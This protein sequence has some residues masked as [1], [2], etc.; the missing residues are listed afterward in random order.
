[1]Q[2]RLSGEG[3]VGRDGGPPGNLYVYLEV[4]EHEFFTRDGND[5]IYL[6]PINL[7]E[8]AL[9]VEK[10]IPTLNDAQETLKVPQGTQPG[11]EFRIRGKGI[12][13][14]QSSRRGDLRVLV[15][16]QVPRSL[17]AHQKELLEELSRSFNFNGDT[18]DVSD[19]GQDSGDK[20]NGGL[21]NKIKDTFV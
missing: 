13:H 12:P 21:F 20:R 10:Q 18:G 7:A 3:D 9:G 8:A 14:L 2:V 6:L 11:A 19:P 17:D 5:L 4:R 16:M 15:D 1:M